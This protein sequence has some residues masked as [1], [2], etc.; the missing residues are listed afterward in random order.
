MLM[1]LVDL[2]M[3]LCVVV[4]LLDITDWEI[5]HGMMMLVIHMLVLV[6]HLAHVGW[7]L[8]RDV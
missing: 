7:M 2:R 1:L 5:W 3:V 6:I 4:S 8:G